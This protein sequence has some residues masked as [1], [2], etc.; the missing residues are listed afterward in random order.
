MGPH[1]GAEAWDSDLNHSLEKMVLIR[2]KLH[3]PKEKSVGAVPVG[4]DL[5]RHS[6]CMADLLFLFLYTQHT[7]KFLCAP[8]GGPF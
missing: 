1:G 8:L 6:A 4:G 7:L 2:T 3:S 5:E